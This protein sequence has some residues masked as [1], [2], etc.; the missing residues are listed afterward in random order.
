MTWFWETH[1]Y[2]I[3]N[4]WSS[5]GERR[6]EMG[7]GKNLSHWIN[8]SDDYHPQHFKKFKGVRIC[9]PYL[10]SILSPILLK[11]SGHHGYEP[12]IPI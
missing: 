10:E 4:Q 9:T 1:I 11:I 6:P 2:L 7:T 8:E 5:Q 12:L 3:S